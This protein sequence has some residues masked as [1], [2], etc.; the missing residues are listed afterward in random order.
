MG[1]RGA[2]KSEPIF[3]RQTQPV[4]ST[5]P[6]AF[7]DADD[8]RLSA[9]GA[10]ALAFALALAPAYALASVSNAVVA[11]G[12]STGGERRNGPQSQDHRGDVSDFL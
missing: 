2:P 10:S 8:L 9:T 12:R 1:A 4:Y 11:P 6:D 7:S 3:C 5:E